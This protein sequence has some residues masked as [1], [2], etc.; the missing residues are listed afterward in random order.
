M[1][2]QHAIDELLSYIEVEKNLSLNTYRSYEYDLH[3]FVQF[4]KK[5]GRS[6]EFWI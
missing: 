2:I 6:M 3:C 5:H 4:L 1:I